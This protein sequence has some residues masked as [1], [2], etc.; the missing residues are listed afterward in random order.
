MA[1]HRLCQS[2]TQKLQFIPFTCRFSV[3]ADIF[4]CFMIPKLP[5]YT[6]KD[7]LIILILLPPVVLLINYWIFGKRYFT[8]GKLFLL[9]SLISGLTGFI[10]W[11]LQILVAVR[12][13][14]RY[15]R[16]SQTF[17]R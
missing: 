6:R 10:S 12:M 17:R 5:Y 11:R 3:Q 7:R 4:R 2:N 8:E 14:R 15:P 9:T 16:Y 13:H 1:T